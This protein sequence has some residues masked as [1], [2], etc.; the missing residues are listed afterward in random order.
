MPE[1][2]TVVFVHGAFAD[3]SGWNGVIARLTAAG[4][5]CHAPANPLRGVVEDAEYVRSFVDALDGPVVLVGH[6]Y[7]G[8]TITNAA[9]GSD[10]VRALVYVC[11]FAPE[12]GE[13]L[14][15]LFGLGG[16]STELGDH[17]V[18][19]PY[20]GAPDGAADAYIA[21]E[22][23]HRL[24][25]ADVPADEA[26]LMEAA[27]RGYSTAALT[28]PSG[29]PGWRS[30]PS[31]FLVGSNDRTIPPPAQRTMAARAGAT[32]VEVDS[33]HVAMVS[34]PQAVADLVLDAVK[35]LG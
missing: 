1:N 19:R 9:A 13:R 26:A 10:G 34:N 4:Y 3:A 20:P 30:I 27:Q 31:W 15:D 35:S 14:A 18:L 25:C 12:E 32:V 7:G 33:S 6:S 22:H 17:L 29:T 23:F 24:F 11:A 28:T 8:C 16:G 2:P 5:R 21:A